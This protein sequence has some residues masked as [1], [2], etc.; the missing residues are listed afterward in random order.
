VKGDRVTLKFK[1]TVEMPPMKHHGKG[2]QELQ[3][4]LAQQERL[5]EEKE[6]TIR[7]NAPLFLL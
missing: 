2:I 5:L 1:L 6:E 4:K 3:A 7:T